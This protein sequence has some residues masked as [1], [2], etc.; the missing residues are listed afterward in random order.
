MDVPTQKDRRTDRQ[1]DTQTGKQKRQSDRQG[2]R[3]T[4]KQTYIPR[5]TGHT[6]IDRRMEDRWT[7]D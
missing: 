2:D 6:Q 1:A 4:E 3:Q 5:D 7:D